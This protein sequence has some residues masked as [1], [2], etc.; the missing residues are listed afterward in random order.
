MASL[1]SIGL[2]YRGKGG[3]ATKTERNRRI[4]AAKL[5]SC[6]TKSPSQGKNEEWPHR[7]PHR[8]V[9]NGAFRFLH[10]NQDFSGYNQNGFAGRRE[11][12]KRR[13]VLILMPNSHDGSAGK[14]AN[15]FPFRF[16][17]SK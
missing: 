10:I 11:K 6:P 12:K 13:G 2:K 16:Y 3:F 4:G 7:K 9:Q 14:T 17:V 8:D 1:S 15:P 5:Q